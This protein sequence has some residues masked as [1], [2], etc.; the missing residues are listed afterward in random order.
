MTRTVGR[1]PAGTQSIE[2]ALTLLTAFT[3]EHPER[4]ISE[5]VTISGLGQSTVSRLVGA[6]DAFGLLAQDSRSG[7]YRIG[8]RAVELSAL[9]LNSSPVFIAARQ[10]AQDLAAAHELG[11][12]VAERDGDHLFYLCHFEG[13]LAPRNFTLVGAGGPLHATA[14]GKA[15]LTGL[16]DEAVEELLGTE[17]QTQTRHT[18][19][20]LPDLLKAL[21]EVRS[22][23][24]A[25]ELEELAF[26]RACVAAPIRDRTGSV[27]A[28][29]SVSGPLSAL[30]LGTREQ[31][32]A[33]SVIEAA[34]RISTALGY[35]GVSRSSA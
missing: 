30:N 17:Y 22:R 28:A 20:T 32:L 12:N 7:L 4:R 15:L 31:E 25:V 26:S 5:L 10:I 23:G 3:A 14:L 16:S 35:T 19:A 34:D 1:E 24:Y 9:A 27:V 29:I 6:L 33:T 21:S 18:I 13:R 8:P 11:A 2:R